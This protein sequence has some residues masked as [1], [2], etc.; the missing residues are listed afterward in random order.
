MSLS[1][2]IFGVALCT[3]LFAGQ[4]SAQDSA[5]TAAVRLPA[6]SMVKP[7]PQGGY[8]VNFKPLSEIRVDPRMHDQMLPS[9]CSESLM[10]SSFQE[11]R[12]ALNRSEWGM[13]VASWEPPNVFL[14]A[15]LLR[16]STAGTLRANCRHV[17]AAAAVRDS[18]HGGYRDLAA[19]SS[20]RPSL[21]VGQSRRIWSPRFAQPLH[22]R[23]LFAFR[24]RPALVSHRAMPIQLPRLIAAGSSPTVGC[25]RAVICAGFADSRAHAADSGRA[26]CP[27]PING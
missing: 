1:Y 12:D 23:T 25:S 20:G 17:A 26:D 3:G 16:Q 15:A 27:G 11:G 14:P 5:A 19:E 22:S 18:L 24:A 9:D 6:T 10:A 7:C 4:S 8:S 21:P 2:R 13:T